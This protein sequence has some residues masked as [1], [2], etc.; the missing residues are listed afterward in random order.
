MRTFPDRRKVAAIAG[1][2]AAYTLAGRALGYRFGLHTPVRC[3]E[4]HT[5]TT[6]WIPGIKLTAIDLVVARFQ[7]CPVGDHWSLVTPVR[8]K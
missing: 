5:F 4:G 3:R 1:G 2:I 6:F 7:H 8:Q